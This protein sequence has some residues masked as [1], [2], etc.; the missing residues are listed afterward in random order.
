MSPLQ[1]I[2]RWFESLPPD[3]RQTIAVISLQYIEAID[4]P[5][6]ALYEDGGEN[7]LKI[8]LTCR[9]L[10]VSILIGR[11]AYFRAVVNLKCKKLFAAGSP[12]AVKS[13]ER[14][15]EHIRATDNSQLLEMQ[16][17]RIQR[18]PLSDRMWQ[19]AGVAW[20]ALLR[21]SLSDASLNG[22]EDTQRF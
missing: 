9:E 4:A 15:I 2:S 18:L 6:G 13:D 20:E 21:S 16:L 12:D 17:N 19:K 5:A 11:A 8:W 3:L 10:P 7:A 22:Y 1:D 14:F